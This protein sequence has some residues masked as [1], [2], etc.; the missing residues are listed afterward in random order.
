MKYFFLS[1][2]LTFRL[3]SNY[4][5]LP[6]NEYTFLTKKA[7]SLFTLKKYNE[8]ANLY[9]KAFD[10]NGGLGKVGHR[11][12]AASCWALIKYS[13][14]AFSQLDKI[15]G[16]GNFTGYEMIAND[17]NFNSLHPDSRWSS[18]MDK[19]KENKSKTK[20]KSDY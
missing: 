7:D 2:F 4:G 1:F 6:L 3:L 9:S 11:Y 12:K 5:Q 16:K 10:L 15:A 20:F 17:S 8:A 14:S 18:L 19:I 13:D